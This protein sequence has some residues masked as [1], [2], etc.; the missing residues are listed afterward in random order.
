MLFV[1]DCSSEPSSHDVLDAH[2]RANSLRFLSKPTA[3]E[4][5]S[6]GPRLTAESSTTF[7][8]LSGKSSAYVAPN[9]VP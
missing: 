7:P 2:Q 3:C 9:K 1:T 5:S 4:T 6:L 8:V